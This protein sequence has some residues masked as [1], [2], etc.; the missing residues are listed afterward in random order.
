MLKTP[1]AAS[2][3]QAG[4]AY[5][6]VGNNEIYELFQS[7]WSGASYGGEQ[8]EEEKEDDRVY[9]VNA[10]GQGELINQDLSGPA[11]SNQIKKTQL[12]VIVEHLHEV[13]EAERAKEVMKPW[14]P[15]LPN[16]LES[17]HTKEV[18][19]SASFV[20]G[21][22]TLGLG[23]IDV[24]EE[25]IQ[26]EYVLDL[27]KNGHFLYMASSGYG[28]S[29]LLTN[30]VLGL[31]MKNSVKLLN[32]YILDLGNSALIP[33]KGLPHVADY[34][35]LDD[36]EKIGKFQK[37]ILDEITDRKRKFAKAMAQNIYVYNE[38]Q[39]VPLKVIVILIDNF[40]T[41]KELG[42]TAEAFVQKVARDGASLGIYLCVTM[43]RVNAMRSSAQNNFKEKIGG[44]NFEQSENRSLLGRSE[45]TLPEDKKGRALVKRENINVMQLYTPV[46]C[47]NELSYNANLKALIA[48]VA[49]AS[50]EE[51]AKGIPVLPEELYYEMLP[52]YP[53]YRNVLTEIPVGI[54]VGN[55]D[56]QYLNVKNEA[57]LIIGMS[58]MG[59]TNTLK[60]VLRH[61]AGQ[62]IY[63]F[64][65]KNG[66][67][68]M[69]EKEEK[70]FY[71]G[72]ADTSV[73]A[74][75]E[76]QTE[77]ERRKELYEKQAD[78]SIT[79]KEYGQSQEPVFVLVDVVQELHERLRGDD[80]KLDILA[81]AVRSGIYVIVTADA[82]LRARNS[83]FLN[84]LA[85]SKCGLVLG[86]IRE[87]GIF[88]YTGLREENRRVDLGYYHARGENRKTKL[89][90]HE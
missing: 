46:P 61:I 27:M 82:K 40:D 21:D 47:E 63:L 30:I 89:I 41:M 16:P 56:I 33:L 38:S 2:I 7:A 49:E 90:E 10:L 32:F 48:E 73:E 81:E 54:E 3:T 69:Y 65:A 60:N 17:P 51:R 35:G 66:N 39:A 37:R 71:A 79:L 76:I 84:M 12:D 36:T 8:T 15:S 70:L 88:S 29:M 19:D 78:V 53:G 77:T 74:L 58:G 31:A 22:Y 1:D 57:A 28:K 72:N 43:T 59:R 45:Y 83:E 42:D 64:D 18:R 75:K 14:L 13:Y 20:K 52:E 50:T 67:L 5:L 26:E 80:G 6:Q 68:R 87:Q 4:R 9:L 44:Y 55:L 34:M 11:D 25:Q 23:M 85:E 62:K 86:N 24:P